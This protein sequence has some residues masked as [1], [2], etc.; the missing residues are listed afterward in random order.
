MATIHLR[1][2]NP[3]DLAVDVWQLVRPVRELVDGVAMGPQ[4]DPGGWF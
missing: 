1:R 2:Q 4:S 3:H